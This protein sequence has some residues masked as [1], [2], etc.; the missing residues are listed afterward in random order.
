MERHR[1]QEIMSYPYMLILQK[2][3]QTVGRLAGFSL[4]LR[5]FLDECGDLIANGCD[6]I[7]KF[8]GRHAQ[9]ARNNRRILH[10]PVCRY[11]ADCVIGSELAH[12]DLNIGICR[13]ILLGK[14]NAQNERKQRRN[15]NSKA[16]SS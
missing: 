5:Q 3:P 15:R 16:G 10:E 1:T 12:H 6:L 9:N 14:D 13:L 11:H 2:I 4:F 7:L 8:L